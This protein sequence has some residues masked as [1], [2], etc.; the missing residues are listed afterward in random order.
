MNHNVI[1]MAHVLF[2]LICL[3]AAVW[4]FVDTL[5]AAD[6]N[7]GRIRAVSLGAAVAMLIAYLIA[8]YWYI[9]FARASSTRSS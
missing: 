6:A 5:H 4:V 7:L 3:I 8:G 2:G 9:A 1:L